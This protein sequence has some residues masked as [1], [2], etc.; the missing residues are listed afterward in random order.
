M[1]GGH[2]QLVGPRSS[3]GLHLIQPL[4]K[5]RELGAALILKLILI[6]T[7]DGLEDRQELRS[8]FADGG[9]FSLICRIVSERS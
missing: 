5:L 3:A 2:L 4:D 6:A 9:V 1:A 7:K 8:K